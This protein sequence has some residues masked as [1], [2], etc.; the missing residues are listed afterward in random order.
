MCS[1]HHTLLDRV[2]RHGF[3]IDEAEVIYTS[4][5]SSRT[6]PMIESVSACGW[7][8]TAD[9]TA[10]RGRVTRRATPRN[11][12]SK[13]EVVGAR[14]RVA[15]FLESIKNQA[16]V[17]DL[18]FGRGEHATWPAWL[19]K[20][21]GPRCLVFGRTGEGPLLPHGWLPLSGIVTVD[22][23]AAPPAAGW[24]CGRRWCT[25]PLLRPGQEV[26][27]QDQHDRKTRP[28][29]LRSLDSRWS[30]RRT[31]L[32]CQAPA[33][34]CRGRVVRVRSDSSA[35]VP[36]QLAA[37]HYGGPPASSR[38]RDGASLFTRG[39]EQPRASCRRAALCGAA[40]SRRDRREI[41]TCRLLGP[42][43]TLRPAFGS[44]SISLFPMN[45]PLRWRREKRLTG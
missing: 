35:A 42:V 15:Q 27:A 6:A 31:L 18:M 20:A 40:R 37:G 32:V 19:P 1:R 17:L 3:A 12:C 23:I 7:S 9:S 10:T 5:R 22:P 25:A 28:P 24:G 34:R 4:P 43:P 38:L 33:H 39:P 26:A 11:M 41:P 44:S 36:R 16:S 14:Q 30:P 13:S 8:C 2:R 21:W 29:R 45:A